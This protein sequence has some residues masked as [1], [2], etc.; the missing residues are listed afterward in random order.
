[1]PR[2]GRNHRR[3]GRRAS[4]PLRSPVRQV[5]AEI[6]AD[7]ARC[8]VKASAAEIRQAAEFGAEAGLRF[9]RGCA[10]QGLDPARQL[11]AVTAVCDVFAEAIAALGRT[12]GAGIDP[13]AL[14]RQVARDMEEAERRA[15][16]GKPPPA[17][18]DG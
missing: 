8:G 16:G 12:G 6:A 15:L 3:D 17:P 5:E 14:Q 9:E 11:A 4:A 1:M 7:L 2:S 13:A 10:E 18:G